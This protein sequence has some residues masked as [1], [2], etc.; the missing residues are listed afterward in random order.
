[1]A[2]AFI[3]SLD[4]S[5]KNF[6]PGLTVDERIPLRSQYLSLLKCLFLLRKMEESEELLAAREPPSQ[7]HWPSYV[8]E[9]EEVCCPGPS[10]PTALTVDRN[11]PMSAISSPAA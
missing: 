2:D 4:K 3:T 5:T 11:F 8:K 1:M 7:S 9:L 6:K 10:L